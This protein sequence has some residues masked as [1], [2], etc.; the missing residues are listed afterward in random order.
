[1]SDTNPRITVTH[2][3]VNDVQEVLEDVVEYL[4]REEFNAGRLIAGESVWKI[5]ECLAVAKQA[6]M[7]GL[8][9]PDD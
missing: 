3:L 9:V 2:E 7:Q 1:M 8:C 4:V 6:E 5:I